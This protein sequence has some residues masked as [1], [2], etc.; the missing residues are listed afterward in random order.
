M[1]KIGTIVWT[2][3]TIPNAEEVRDFYKEVVGWQSSDVEMGDYADFSMDAPGT[4]QTV[5][6]I[7]HARGDNA[8][9]PP[10]WLIYI[11]VENLDASVQACQRLGGNVIS[12]PRQV[13]ADRFCVIRDPAGAVMALYQSG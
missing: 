13:G 8:S 9:Q 7:C 4:N 11:L 6:G 2:D 10:Q 1:A 3:L 5:A 12:G